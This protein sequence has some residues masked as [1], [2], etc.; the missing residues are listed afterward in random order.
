HGATASVDFEAARRLF[1]S[2]DV[3]VAH[4]LFVAGRLKVQ[5]ARPLFDAMELFAF[6]RPATPCVPS[7][8]GLARACGLLPPNTPEDSAMALQE[9]VNILLDELKSKPETERAQIR[10]LASTLEKSGWRWASFV[11]DSV[12][13]PETALSPIAGFDSWRGLPQWEDEAAPDKPGSVPVE[14]G[15][16]RHRLAQ[17][18]GDAGE[19]RPE[20][21]DYAED[22][23]YAFGARERAGAPRIALIEAGTGI[24]KTL[25]Y[26]APASVWAEKNAPGLW[27]STY[28]SNLQRQIV[29]E[30]ARL[31]PDPAE[32]EDKAVVRKGRENYLCLLNFEEAARRTALAP[33]QRAIALGLVSRWVAATSDGDLSGQNFPAFLA[34]SFPLSEVTDRRGEC[35]YA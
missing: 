21:E 34:G 18:V 16:A 2:G 30:I 6:V 10:A 3:I 31:Y 17:L 8:L 4:A 12:G 9:A 35:I 7:A 14:A 5:P 33:G 1:R 25:G 28:T 23:T 29:Q 32:R 11:L 19:V 20:Q 22:A 27:P 24:G 15:E 13:K 26:L